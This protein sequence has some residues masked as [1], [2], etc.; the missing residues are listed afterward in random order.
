MYVQRSPRLS[1]Y[2]GKYQYNMTHSD[3][4]MAGQSD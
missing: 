3:K 4:L 2:E 1:L